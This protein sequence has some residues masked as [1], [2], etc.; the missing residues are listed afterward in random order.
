MTPAIPAPVEMFELDISEHNENINLTDEIKTLKNI[1]LVDPTN[2]VK[3][4]HR[5]IAFIESEIYEDKPID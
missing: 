4:I 5:T 3:D 2:L 1:A